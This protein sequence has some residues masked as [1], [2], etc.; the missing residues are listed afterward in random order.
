MDVLAY[1][2]ILGYLTVGALY[3]RL[4]STAQNAQ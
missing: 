1:I 4:Q 3:Q 2:W